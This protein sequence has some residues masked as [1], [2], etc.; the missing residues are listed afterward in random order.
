MSDEILISAIK[1]Y[2]NVWANVERVTEDPPW[3]Q[4][5][6]GIVSWCLASAAAIVVPNR[7]LFWLLGPLFQCFYLRAQ[8]LSRATLKIFENQ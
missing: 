2:Q 1:S 7:Q 4:S 3:D 6:F 5:D 8:I